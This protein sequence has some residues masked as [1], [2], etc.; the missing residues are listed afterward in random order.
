MKHYL[1]LCA[2][3]KNEA[4]YLEE[5]LRFYRQIGV[6]H[7]FLFDNGS[8]DGTID[9][10][11][12]WRKAGWATTYQTHDSAAQV[13]IYRHCLNAHAK[14]SHWIIFVDIDE[15]F[16]SPRQHDLRVLLQDYEE[17]AG[18]V[19]NWL[20]FGASGH[21]CR[22]TG[23]TTLNF[24]RRCEVDLCTFEP[25]L[26][27]EPHL[28]PKDPQSYH[29]V[30]EHVKSIINTRDVLDIGP[31]PHEFRYRPGRLP[32]NANH[33][34]ISGPFSD[35]LSAVQSLRINHY[36]SRSWEEFSIKLNRGRADTGEHYDPQEMIRRNLLFDQVIDEEIFPIARRVEAEMHA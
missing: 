27:K 16:Y 9:L 23:L 33:L 8:T 14:D 12:R 18:V 7:F 34:P 2:I 28:E 30:C 26:L 31:S 21:Q 32:V 35:D 19:A 10:L 29:K 24:T 17:E 15:F 22:P 20:M 1:S 5:W 6:E 36:F 11:A 13:G 3:L 25:A 4:T